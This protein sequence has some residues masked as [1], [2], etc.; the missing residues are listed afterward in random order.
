ML[1]S[2]GAMPFAVRHGQRLDRGA[3]AQV[4]PAVDTEIHHVLGVGFSTRLGVGRVTEDVFKLGDIPVEF[5]HSK[6][7]GQWSV[8]SGQ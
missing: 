1:M 2:S 3:L 8:A 6:C 5:L 7:S 4:S